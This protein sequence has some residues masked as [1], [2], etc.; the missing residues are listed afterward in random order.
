MKHLFLVFVILA[1]AS[2]LTAILVL[3]Q[4]EPEQKAPERAR[5][6]VEVL[7]VQPE[8]VALTV[9]S[10]GTVLPKTESDLAIEVSGRIIEVADN[11]RPGASI[12]KGDVLFKIDP[13]DYKAAVAARAAELASAQLALAQEA[14]LAEQAAAD[15][16]ALGTGKPSDLTLRKPQLAQ[17]QALVESAL[18]NLAR[19]ERDLSRTQ[20]TAPYDG[21]VLTQSVDLGQYV[22][23]NPAGS[24]ARIFATDRAEVRLP[25]SEREA[26]YLNNPES[27]P[28]PVILKSGNRQW[29]G[30]LVRLEATIDPSSRLLYAVA[31]VEA[32]FSGPDAMRRGLFV[33]ALIEGRTMGNVYSIPRYALRG[34]NTVYVLSESNTLMERAVS[35]VKSDAQTVIIGKGLEP[36][37]QVAT[38]PIAYYVENMP[39]EV[40]AE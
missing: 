11:F 28:S 13:A 5:A 39:I 30:T 16:K 25:I 6:S 18:A 34:S 12:R 31:E 10:Q 8:S 15:W 4:P 37:D 7:T 32:P 24:A 1:V 35:I 21:R 22:M 40:I 20:V 36:G 38:S 2:G 9:Q 27:T 23:A 33:D 19:A 14:A 17:A 26:G 29:S 3:T